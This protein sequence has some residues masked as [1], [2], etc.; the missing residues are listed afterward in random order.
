[1]AVASKRNPNVFKALRALA[2]LISVPFLVQFLVSRWT[3]APPGEQIS[4]NS[5]HN[6]P[7]VPSADPE[8]NVTL[9]ELLRAD[10]RVSRFADV[11]GE[12]PDIVRG[13]SAPKAKFTVYAPVNEAF[14]SFYFPP[15]PPPFFGLF[16]AGY[17]MGPGFV[18]ADRLASVGTVSSFVN[19]DIFFDYKQR[20][21]V[22][23]NPDGT[24]TFN[25]EA[26]YIPP[27]DG[28]PLVAANGL[29]HY[30][31]GV[32]GLP[33]ST[34]HAV[35]THPQLSTLERALRQTEMAERV[36]DTNAHISQT[37]FAPTNAAF[38][39]LGKTA[40]KFLFTRAGR[41]YLDAILRF[42]VVENQ[43]LFSDMYWPHGGADLLDL[44]VLEESEKEFNLPTLHRSRNITVQ[45]HK[46]HGQWKLRV[47]L[48]AE[49]TGDGGVHVSVSDI[50]A[51]DGVVH[52]VDSLLLPP[53]SV[54]PEEKSWLS[55][56]FQ[57]GQGRESIESLIDRL[58]PYIVDTEAAS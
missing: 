32:L 54:S 44:H 51:M 41:P 19:G 33:N 46:V 12:L 58:E 24:T 37:I 31:G 15:D 47:F 48:G 55:G 40:K 9:W 13:L 42:H 26:D 57:G 43:T 50:L 30:I 39:R 10:A 34:A 27:T 5:Q 45:N 28:A 2:V 22:Q 52:L 7:H 25:H 38:D 36:Y 29:M 16:L 56:L 21:S 14:D 1:M 23:H 18:P 4:V 20:I 53:R 35:R 49:D 6:K 8:T 17:H 3:R 11:I